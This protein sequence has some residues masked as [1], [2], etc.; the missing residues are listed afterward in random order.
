MNTLKLYVTFLCVNV[1]SYKSLMR[2]G[3]SSPQNLKGSMV[4]N[5][6]N[7]EQEVNLAPPA[8]I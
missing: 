6:R 3:S 7:D 8:S 5:R 2:T 4:S 1:C